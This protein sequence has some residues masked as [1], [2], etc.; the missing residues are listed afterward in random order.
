MCL[1]CRK[2]YILGTTV[3][4][5][6]ERD[7]VDVGHVFFQ[8]FNH[9]VFACLPCRNY[10]NVPDSQACIT[11][12]RVIEGFCAVSKNKGSQRGALATRIY[13]FLLTVLL[14]QGSQPFVSHVH[15]QLSDTWACTSSACRQMNNEHV[16]LKSRMAKY[17]I[18]VIHRYIQQYLY[19]FLGR[20]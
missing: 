12:F 13:K 15:F 10:N 16:P 18:M 7:K 4:H 19:N 14:E 11:Q 6:E 1:V 17:F 2:L 9:D 20:V 5:S 8:K 3:E